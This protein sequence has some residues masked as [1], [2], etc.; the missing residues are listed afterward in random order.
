MPRGILTL[1][2]PRFKIVI[3]LNKLRREGLVSAFID[4]LPECQIR[5]LYTSVSCCLSKNLIPLHCRATARRASRKFIQSRRFEALDVCFLHLGDSCFTILPK[6]M[7]SH[8]SVGLT[9]L[10]ALMVRSVHTASRENHCGSDIF[11]Q[12][13]SRRIF[14]FIPRAGFT[15][16]IDDK[17]I[18]HFR[19]LTLTTVLFAI[20]I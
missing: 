7:V 1:P 8:L 12:R 4:R 20:C 13:I 10:N 19:E 15:R 18:E 16:H 14:R 2:G 6:Q 17:L 3:I 9:T 11:H 5:I